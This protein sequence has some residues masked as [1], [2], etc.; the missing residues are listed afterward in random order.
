MTRIKWALLLFIVVAFIA[1][2]LQSYGQGG[3]SGNPLSSPFHRQVV[4][5]QRLSP[6]D[7]GMAFLPIVTAATGTWYGIRSVPTEDMSTVA[8]YLGGTVISVNFGTQNADRVNA[9]LN[10]AQSLGY[11]VIVIMYT[12]ETCSRR[13]WVWTGNQWRF[14]AST[15]ETLQ[16]IAHHSALFAIYALHEPFDYTNGCHWTVEQQQELY[17][18]LKE[19]TDGA[20]VWT[21]I[22][23]LADWVE[24]GIE[25]TDGMCD[26][27]AT[28]RHRFRSDWSSERC[29]EETLN[30]I[31]AN[32]EVQQRMMPNSQLVFQIQA[33][34]YA[35]PSLPY[36]LPT[37]EEL[38]TVREHLCALQQ[39][40][41]YYPWSHGTYD[42]S[43]DDAPSLWPVVAQGCTEYG[44]TVVSSTPSQAGHVGTTATYVLEIN[45]KGTVSDTFDVNASGNAWAIV[46]PL[47][48]VPVGAGRATSVDIEVSIPT[49]AVDGEQDQATITVISQGDPT[50]SHACTLTT[51][52]TWHKHFLPLVGG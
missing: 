18:L 10:R 47:T 19:Y 46:A 14:P 32:L 48:T 39:P 26:Y 28:F 8:E 43:L 45:N 30:A 27:C 36:R 40:M 23:G 9:Q 24:R 51:S 25:P 20:A 6:S 37:P 41:M 50:Q 35:G 4:R 29:L 1:M 49:S 5:V 16:G 13:P 11:R 2:L 52:A 42:S 21:D 33:F 22:G 34:S 7:Q 3:D 15:I 17:Q 31:D 38:A 44:V 12:R